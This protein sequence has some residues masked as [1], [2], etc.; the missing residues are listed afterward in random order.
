MNAIIVC[1]GL[2]TRLG[3]ITKH[4]P[5]VLLAVGDHTVL[6]WQLEKLKK[7][8]ISRVV[9]AAGH[10][11]DALHREVGNRHRDMDLV[12]AIESERLGTGGAVKHAMEYLDDPEA[13]TIVLNG[14]VLSTVDF[15]DMRNRLPQGSEGI[16]LGTK[17]DDASSYG[18]LIYDD[19]GHLKEFREKEGIAK[20]GYINGSVYLFTAQVKTY[21]PDRSAFSMEYDIF[22]KMKNVYVY[23]SDL[24][25]ID[26]GVPDRLQWARDHWKIFLD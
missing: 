6:E 9:L 5:K 18:T 19:V 22:P 1:G 17:V 8:G 23:E 25:W 24:P 21:F 4:I 13:P 10:L 2:S 20:P 26:I 7:L 14:D 16:I 12:Y 3:D 11:A 15:G